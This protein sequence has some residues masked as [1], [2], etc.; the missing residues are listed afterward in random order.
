[1]II[2]V[3]LYVIFFCYPDPDQRFLKWPNDTDP[4]GSGSETL[5]VNMYQADSDHKMSRGLI[6]T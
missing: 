3:D 5:G 6:G 4:T 2:L 1:M